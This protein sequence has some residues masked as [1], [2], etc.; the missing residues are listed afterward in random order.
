[1]KIGAFG[2]AQSLIDSEDKPECQSWPPEV[3]NT[4]IILPGG[5]QAVVHPEQVSD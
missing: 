4:I 5:S 3:K 1:M 2:A